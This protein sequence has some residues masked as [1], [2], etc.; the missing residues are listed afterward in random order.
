M[1]LAWRFQRLLMEWIHDKT[2]VKYFVKKNLNFNICFKFRLKKI[3]IQ[4]LTIRIKTAGGKSPATLCIF[5]HCISALKFHGQFDVSFCDL[6]KCWFRPPLAEPH[7]Q[8]F[9]SLPTLRYQS[10][11]AEWYGG[12]PA[13]PDDN[14]TLQPN[15]TSRLGEGGWTTASTRHTSLIMYW[16]LRNT[17][18]QLDA[19]VLRNPT[20]RNVTRLR[21]TRG[22]C[23]YSKWFSQPLVSRKQR[24]TKISTYFYCVA[25][26]GLFLVMA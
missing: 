1:A 17:G 26:W 2:E 9:C 24:G 13:W 15:S 4:T 23:W 5:K 22:G 12:V 21:V 20:T 11:P 7:C 10:G 18:C 19:Y 25:P 6:S 14:L 3:N 8:V 16:C